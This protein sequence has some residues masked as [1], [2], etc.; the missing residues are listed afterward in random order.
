VCHGCVS[1]VGTSP[2]RLTQPW[3][4]ATKPLE[5]LF[6]FIGSFFAR[7][8]GTFL[9]RLLTTDCL[10]MRNLNENKSFRA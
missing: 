2:P 10:S 9:V 6:A 1:R 7:I 4:A 8:R 3:H 5:L